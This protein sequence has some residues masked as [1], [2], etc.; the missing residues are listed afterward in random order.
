[1]MQDIKLTNANRCVIKWM[2]LVVVLLTSTSCT[3]P[4]MPATTSASPDIFFP[5]RPSQP[6]GIRELETGVVELDTYMLALAKG[7]LVLE[8]NCLWLRSP[9]VSPDLPGAQTLVIWPQDF[10]LHVGGTKVEVR[11][12]S[13]EVAARVGE[14][15]SMGGGVMPAE[16]LVEE[17]LAQI[18]PECRD[19]SYWLANPWMEPMQGPPPTA[20]PGITPEAREAW[21]IPPHIAVPCTALPEG[22]QV[23]VEPVSDGTLRVT[24]EGLQPGERPVFRYERLAE[25]TPG[26]PMITLIYGPVDPV[27]ERG[28]FEHEHEVAL[29]PSEGEAEQAIWVLKVIHTRGVAC[30][31]INLN[32]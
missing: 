7:E 23:H 18:P 28:Y 25:L 2:L 21:Q 5:Q 17:I 16:H 15:V 12:E 9:P 19:D 11:N 27:G 6:R 31:E 30:T 26:S 1:M 10:T 29:T 8:R 32:P 24:V 3:P 20:L 14:W 4:N 13:G 22:L